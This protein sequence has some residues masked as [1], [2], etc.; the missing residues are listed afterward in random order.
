MAAE[1]RRETGLPSGKDL[2]VPRSDSLLRERGTDPERDEQIVDLIRDRGDGWLDHIG[3]KTG[4]GKGF[5][6][7]TLDAHAIGGRAG[8]IGLL[9]EE[10]EICPAGQETQPGEDCC[11]FGSQHHA[12]DGVEKQE[13]GGEMFDAH[14]HQT[15]EYS[16]GVFGNELLEGDKEG[17]LDR[18]S[19]ADLS[20]AY[21][22]VTP[23]GCPQQIERHDNHIGE[24]G[25]GDNEFGK[26][27][28][29][30]GTLKVLAA[31]EEGG[32]VQKDGEDVLL[33]KGGREEGPWIV[34]ES[35]GNESQV[36]NNDGRSQLGFA[37]SGTDAANLAPSGDVVE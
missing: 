11:G 1:E 16:D 5:A 36:G 2:L 30:P 14:L 4:K 7:V 33:D 20:E 19:T 34:E 29:T 24:D 6:C 27:P 28:R 3:E 25:D 17:G 9:L 10:P 35:Q 12:A 31:V 8:E 18:D 32:Q 13:D 26:L 37:G 22:G 15:L 21:R 23:D